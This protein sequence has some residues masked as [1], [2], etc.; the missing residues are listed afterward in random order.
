[1]EINEL[2]LL[3]AGVGSIGKRHAEV[4]Y[5]SLGCKNIVL[6]DKVRSNALSFAQ[7]F[8][9]M[10][11]VDSFESGLG[12]KPDAVF[13]T[14]PAALHMEQALKALEADC[15]V[16]VEK[17]LDISFDNTGKVKKLA[18]QKKRIVSVA[19]CY[20]HHTG[21]IRGKEIASSGKIGKILNVRT[22]M[23]QF[24][25]DGRP[26]YK[27]TQYIVNTGAFEFS[28]VID[29]AFWV[30]GGEPVKIAGLTCNSEN[31]GYVAPDSAE[32][33]FQ[34][35]TGVICNVTMDCGRITG[36]KDELSIY[37]TNGCVEIEYTVDGY[38]LKT[39]TKSDRKGQVEERDDLYRNLL[40]ERE[41]R[42]FLEDI[43]S[44]VQ[45][46]CTVADAERSLKVYWEV[47]GKTLEGR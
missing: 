27:S 25:P 19:Y 18:A 47:Y 1:M 26:D 22:R 16:M 41:D 7:E 13:I 14:S 3:I 32:V 38:S 4:L 6:Y 46:G 10:E 36:K 21:L 5:S 8:P 31:M 9:G 45:R 42:E 28:H 15:H 12:K 2:K 24:L 37:G 35:G 33:L 11:C 17:P 30:A 29:T 39:Y 20:R 43:L 34:T 40:F 44:G 23:A